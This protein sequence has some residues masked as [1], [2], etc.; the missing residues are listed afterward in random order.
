MREEKRGDLF[1]L[2]ERLVRRRRD[3]PRQ[4]SAHLLMMA[5]PLLVL[6]YRSRLSRATTETVERDRAYTACCNSSSSRTR[7]I[8]SG[9]GTG[10]G[11]DRIA[12][13]SQ[14]AAARWPEERRPG[15][16]LPDRTGASPGL[17]TGPPRR[18]ATP[19]LGG[20]AGSSG[21]ASPPYRRS[22]SPTRVFRRLSRVSHGTM[23][24]P[25]QCKAY[26]W[27]QAVLMSKARK[28]MSIESKAVSINL[29]SRP[30]PFS[31]SRTARA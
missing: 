3:E 1:V 20:R 23:S 26:V 10:T 11:S 7:C 18:R 30:L 9:R 27:V 19:A 28:K 21:P 6:A 13:A 31:R 14:R 8:S 4:M 17:R 22:I 5:R 24:D 12:A 25:G 15:S 16:R 29:R 2:L